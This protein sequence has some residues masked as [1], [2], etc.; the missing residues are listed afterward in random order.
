MQKE[1]TYTEQFEQMKADRKEAVL[2]E[3]FELPLEENFIPPIGLP[4][5]AENEVLI[6]PVM[7]SE[8]KRA[9]GIILVSEGTVANDRKIGI[10]ARCGYLVRKPLRIGQRVIF[11]N[12]SNHFRID[13]SDGN[14]YLMILEHNIYCI[15][16]PQTYVVPEFKTKLMKR[17]EERAEGLKRTNE[18]AQKVADMSVEEKKENN[19]ATDLLGNRKD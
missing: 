12:K 8:T 18:D 13:G 19:I 7:Q 16:T 14:E 17:N 2:K 6:L 15:C 3:I 5:P 11:E 1:L 10:V 9:S 4:I